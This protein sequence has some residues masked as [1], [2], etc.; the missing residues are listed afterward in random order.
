MGLCVRSCSR[1]S[2]T[3]CTV[4]SILLLQTAVISQCAEQQLSD[5]EAQKSEFQ[6]VTHVSDDVNRATSFMHTKR[7]Y[8]DHKRWGGTE[9][10]VCR[11]QQCITIT[12]RSAL[13]V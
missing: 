7:L 3:G 9:D 12:K 10:T 2:K 8:K 1:L 6:D 11:I 5:T 13:H 4:C